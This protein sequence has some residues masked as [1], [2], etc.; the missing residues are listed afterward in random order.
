MLSLSVDDASTA[1]TMQITF[2]NIIQV[3]AQC[4]FKMK[5]K[6]VLSVILRKSGEG[7]AWGTLYSDKMRNLKCLF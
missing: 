2:K 6:E 3:H 7:Q 5:S 4:R 1:L